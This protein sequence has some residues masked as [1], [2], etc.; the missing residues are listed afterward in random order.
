MPLLSLSLSASVGATPARV[1]SLTMLEAAIVMVAGIALGLV[2]LTVATIAVAPMSA[3][4]FGLRLD[5]CAALGREAMLALII[6]A[7]GMSASILP[8]L[9]VYRMTL[10]DGLSF[11]L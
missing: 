9:R 3:A 5:A 1:F 10:A 8:A 6:F 7:A 2:L 11:R 4:Q